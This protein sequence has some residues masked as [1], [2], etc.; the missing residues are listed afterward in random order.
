MLVSGDVWGDAARAG[1]GV[2]E[3]GLEDNCVSQEN[4]GCKTVS[5]YSIA[6][7]GC[8]RS[9]TDLWAAGCLRTAPRL[10]QALVDAVWDDGDWTRGR[11]VGLGA[12]EATHGDRRKDNCGIEHLERV[13]NGVRS[14][15]KLPRQ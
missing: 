5:T 12:S 14:T 6:S 15:I 3:G 10:S 8:V 4:F 9:T 13:R 11:V 1:A 7:V 2:V